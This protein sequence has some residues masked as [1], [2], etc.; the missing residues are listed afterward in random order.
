MNK[1]SWKL[2]TNKV[3]E[4]Y[5]SCT[6]VLCPASWNLLLHRSPFSSRAWMSLA[7]SLMS[8]RSTC[9]CWVM[10]LTL[11]T[12]RARSLFTPG[13]SSQSR[14]CGGQRVK[15]GFN[16]SPAIKE[17]IQVTQTGANNYQSLWKQHSLIL[18]ELSLG[19]SEMHML[20][21]VVVF[22]IH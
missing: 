18:N 9:L 6:S 4:F 15:Q 13:A 8:L 12:L 10:P 20:W 2:I 17:T 14:S 16:A 1:F 3:H 22:Q 5:Q 19:V 11:R 7:A 21:F